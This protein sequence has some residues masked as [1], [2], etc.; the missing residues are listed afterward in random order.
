MEEVKT[1]KITKSDGAAIKYREQGDVAFQVLT[2]S[3][4]MEEPVRVEALM[5]YSITVVPHSLGTPDGFLCKTNKASLVH[6]LSDDYAGPRKTLNQETTCH[7]ED[8]NAIVHLLKGLPPP[9][10]LKNMFEN[11]WNSTKQG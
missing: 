8:D 10:I 11:T 9:N 1:K 2:K 7:I 3:Q 4:M 6:H 5:T